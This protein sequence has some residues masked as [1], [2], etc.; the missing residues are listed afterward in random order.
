MPTSGVAE[1]LTVVS[2]LTSWRF[3]PVTVVLLAVA[4]GLYGWGMVRVRRRHPER[5]WPALRATS[6]F[7]GLAVIAIA[8]L[9]GLGVYQTTLFWVHM[10][11][12]LL[13][14][15]VA[16][17]LLVSG[18]P[19]ILL[20][21]ASR[22]QAHRR[23]KRVL[24]SR[25]VA[26]LTSPLLTVPFYAAV[27]VGTHL[28]GFMN[29]VITNPWAQGG[30]HLLYVVS[31]YLYLLPAFGREPIRWRL[32]N[33]AKILLIIVAMPIDTFTGIALMM[34]RQP[35]WREFVAQNR[36]WGPSPLEDVQ[37]GG[38][39]MWV[40]ADAIMMIFII[41]ALSMWVSAPNRTRLRWVERARSSTM[42]QRYGAQQ[43]GAQRYGG[44]A[45]TGGRDGGVGG[46][47][48]PA[49][50]GS[51]PTIGRKL[52]IDEEQ[53]TAYNAWLERLNRGERT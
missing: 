16:P 43:V 28:T 31:G 49:G 44:A 50:A 12:H 13:L 7:G 36:T 53:L 30:E 3:E 46:A 47:D 37:L 39:I 14:I 2:G 51:G 24:R 22:G 6:Y 18:R 52:D 21:H 41:A 10:V 23:V 25:V 17:A 38:A 19:I 4:A 35:P 9:S 20:L 26:V 11:Q 33:P 48:V 40:G 34:T 1:P 8:L 5:P 15:M 32:S 27:V 29:V 45:G 42:A